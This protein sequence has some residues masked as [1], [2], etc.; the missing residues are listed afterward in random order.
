MRQHSCP[1]QPDLETPAHGESRSVRSVAARHG[2]WPDE[3][4]VRWDGEECRPQLSPSDLRHCYM[5]QTVIARSR[6]SHRARC[7]LALPLPPRRQRGSPAFVGV[8]VVSVVS[9][10]YWPRRSKLRSTK[11]RRSEIQRSADRKGTKLR[12]HMR[13]RPS[14]CVRTSPLTSRTCTCCTTAA[15]DMGNDFPSSLTEAGP[16]PSRSSMSRRPGSASA[17][18]TLSRS[19]ILLSICFSIP[20]ALLNSQGLA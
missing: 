18:K 8:S 17:W 3:A 13:V 11:A 5:S 10:S 19:N 12:L 15:S 2:D 7:A 20:L 1:A 4:P 16:W 9:A 14:F 6:S